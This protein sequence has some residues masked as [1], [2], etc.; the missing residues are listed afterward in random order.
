MHMGWWDSLMVGSIGAA[1]IPFSA[2]LLAQSRGVESIMPL[3]VGLEVAMVGIWIF[4]PS[5]SRID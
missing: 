4:V 1:L 3:L 5:K 2:G